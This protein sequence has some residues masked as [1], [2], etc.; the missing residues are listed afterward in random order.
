MRA[1]QKGKPRDPFMVC[2]RCKHSLHIGY[3]CPHTMETDKGGKYKV[4]RCECHA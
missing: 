2:Q 4:V 1:Q 3:K